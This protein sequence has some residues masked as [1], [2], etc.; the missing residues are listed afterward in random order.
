MSE[1]FMK[2]TWVLVAIGM[3]LASLL[4]SDQT[5]ASEPPLLTSVVAQGQRI[6]VTTTVPSGW[7]HILLE[8]AASVTGEARQPLIAGPLSGDEARVTFNVPIGAEPRF[9]VVRVGS[10]DTV[11]PASHTGPDYIAIHYLDETPLTE[12]EKQLHVLNRIA[13]GPSA[14]DMAWIQTIGV[15]AY[16]NQQLSP[17]VIDEDSNQRWRDAEAALFN[18]ETPREDI[19]IIRPGEIWRYAKGTQA[20]PADW[21]QTGFDDSA[22]LS[23]PSGFGYGDDDDATV[24]QDMRQTA[25]QAGYASVFLRRAFNITDPTTIARLILRVD[26]D[27]GFVAYLNGQEIVRTN[28]AG[29]PPLFSALATRGREA[30]EPIDYDISAHMALLMAGRNVLAIQVHNS[31]LDS[32]DLTLIPSLISRKLLPG[33]PRVRIK[34]IQQLQQLAHVRGVYARRQLQS[35]LADFWDNHFTTDFDKTAEYFDDL[36][37]SDATDAMTPAQAEL[38]AAQAEFEEYQY[39]TDHGLGYF[40]DLLLYS[41][42]SPPMLIYLDTVLNRQGAPNENYAREILE[43]FAFGVDNRYIQKDIEELARCFTGWT[44][45]KIQPTA[46]PAFPGSARNPLTTASVDFDEQVLLEVGSSWR[47]FKGRSEPSPGDGGSPTLSWTTPDFD[48]ASWLSGPT[49]IGFGDNDDATILTDMRGNYGSV[50]LR[51]PFVVHESDDLTGLMLAVAYDDGFVA[52]LNGTE[53]ARSETMAGTG[54]PP[55][56]NRLSAGSREASR[57]PDLFNLQNYLGL[58]RR[59]PQTNIL[60]L[61]VHNVELTSSDLSIHP[62]LIKRLPL[63]GSIENGDPNG[64]WVFRFNPDAH[65]T[66][67][68]LLFAGTP[69]EIKIPAGRT[70]ADGVKDAIDVIDAMVGH[71]STR[72]FVC[73]KLI[74]KFV[75]DDIN[76]VSYH[77]GTAPPALR[78]LLEDAMAAWMSTTPPGHIETVLRAILQP[79]AQ[80]GFFWSQ[81]AAS[82]KIKTPIEFINSSLRALDALP[83]AV[84]LPDFNDRLGMHLFTRDDP[85]GWSELGFDWMDT[86]SLLERIRFVQEL[87]GNS[88]PSMTW[89][90]DAFIRGLSDKSASGI[91][92]HFNALLYRGGMTPAQRDLILRYANSDDQGNPLAL[93]PARG[94]YRRRVQELVS[95]ILSMPQWHSQ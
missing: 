92:D 55:P 1:R 25:T 63:P 14:S 53:I 86:G 76:L 54:A 29:T 23:G 46:R 12:D 11:P 42:T 73:L 81:A 79:A 38:E 58:I 15:E 62:R 59:A 6:L 40:G 50:Y 9:L 7:R 77:N 83:T 75:S 82:V 67:E 71:P 10:E 47:Y 31:D 2:P 17:K 36:D 72:E 66:G 43:L 84:V 22:W 87:A 56:F 20:P 39:W 85:D 21:T 4:C 95:L 93:D 34:G 88:Y 41:A 64:A 80:Q 91:V 32:S 33:E 78:R 37:N 60:A 45:R 70:G 94:D 52:Y 90:V 69:Y 19:F 24:L 30:G 27:D 3:P 61:Q 57:A 65:D 28:L 8:S 89:D 48:D 44:L 68:K 49:S 13:C 5:I 18:V 35:V 51:H 26:F 74:N 16:L